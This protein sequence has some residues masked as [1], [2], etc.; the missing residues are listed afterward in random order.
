MNRENEKR[1]SEKDKSE[2]EQP[3]KKNLKMVI[4]ERNIGKNRIMNKKK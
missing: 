1:N 2:N 4:P 3:E